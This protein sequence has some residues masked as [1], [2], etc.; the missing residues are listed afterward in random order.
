MMG[1][2]ERKTIW[3]IKMI[4]M[5]VKIRKGTKRTVKKMKKVIRISAVVGR[6]EKAYPRGSRI[7]LVNNLLVRTS[8]TK[9]SIQSNK[10]RKKPKNT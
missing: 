1:S 3:T 10:H 7:A 5:I 6:I 4:K 2:K 8:N 9:K